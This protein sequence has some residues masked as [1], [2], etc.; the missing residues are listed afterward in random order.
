MS[1]TNSWAA[2]APP[3]PGPLLRPPKLEPS[4]GE[5]RFLSLAAPSPRRPALRR[6]R[7]PP[8]LSCQRGDFASNNTTSG[9][10]GGICSDWDWNRWNQHF[11]E[12]D[13]AESFSSLLKVSGTLDPPRMPY[14]I[15]S[16]WSS[17]FFEVSSVWSCNIGFLLNYISALFKSK[18]EAVRMYSTEKLNMSALLNHKQL[19]KCRTRTVWKK[20]GQRRCFHNA[21][22]AT[23]ADCVYLVR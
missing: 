10:G 13:Q 1:L 7:G 2:A 16:S 20:K 14:L 22:G 9:G 4:S 11:S 5:L 23:R 8:A 19:E 12:T 21:K 18:I 17:F 6:N 3:P 15:P